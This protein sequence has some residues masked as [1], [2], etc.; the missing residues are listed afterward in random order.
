MKIAVATMNGGLED[1]VAA[2]FGRCKNYTFVEIEGKKIA[3]ASVEE[4]QFANAMGGA[5]IQAAQ[6]IANKGAEAIIAGNFGPNAGQVFSQSGIKMITAQG[7]VKDV[8]TKYISGELT[9][10]QAA[11]Q[12]SGISQASGRGMG[13][14]MGMGMRMAQQPGTPQPQNDQ[15]VSTLEKRMGTI[16]KQL[17]DIKEILE[18][19]KKD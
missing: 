14:G 6:L 16:E 18:G 15:R 1:N 8:A 9:P 3:N 10:S 2:M 11:P 17:K 13:R 4:N 7:N 5:G 12:A 19:L